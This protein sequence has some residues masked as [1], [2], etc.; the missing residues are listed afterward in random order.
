MSVR[1]TRRDVLVAM[2]G[3]AAL[4]AIPAVQ[5]ATAQSVCEEKSD[6]EDE[7]KS[8]RE[9]LAEAEEAQTHLPDE[10][11]ARRRRLI[12]L[13]ATLFEPRFS[14]DTR[15]TAKEIGLGARE[16]IVVLDV[17][18]KFG[19]GTA[20]AWFVTEHE[21]LTN[22]HNVDGEVEILY[23]VTVDG[24]RFEAELVERVESRDPDVALLQTDFTGPSLPVGDS[25]ALSPEDPLVQVGHPGGGDFGYW[26]N[27]LGG[28][29]E[30]E[31]STTLLAT[32]PGLAGNS[33]SPILNL[34]GDVVAMTYG[35][36]PQQDPTIAPTDDE[37]RIGTLN[38]DPF[39]SAVPIETAIERMEAWT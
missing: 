18:E 33:G 4:S 13:H 9:Q 34:Q 11:A 10:I 29:V 37:V 14:T 35:G 19:A 15:A 24:E 7:I 3:M 36:K 25:Y 21:L 38:V 26:V 8:L 6:L 23:G 16:S 39:T 12:E 5:P 32:I 1:N 28:F 22:S 27:T 30:R 31:S 20:T 17:E 2:G